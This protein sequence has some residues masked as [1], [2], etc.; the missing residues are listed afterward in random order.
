MA[1]DSQTFPR[2][3]T[4]ITS[5]PTDGQCKNADCN[6]WNERFRLIDGT[7]R[8]DRDQS[9]AGCALSPGQ[10]FHLALFMLEIHFSLVISFDPVLM[11]FRNNL[12]W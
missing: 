1:F 2:S 9:S 6:R 12:I 8:R 5:S 4:E 7:L 3:R 10:F 11:I